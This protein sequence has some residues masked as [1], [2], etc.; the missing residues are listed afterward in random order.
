M[1]I[2]GGRDDSEQRDSSDPFIVTED[3]LRPGDQVFVYR[4]LIQH[5]G[6]VTRVA[7]RDW[8]LIVEVV[9]FD[10]S[11]DQITRVD[12]S[13]FLKGS[14]GKRGVLRRAKFGSD[15]LQAAFHHSACY[16]HQADPPQ[17]VTNR[18]LRALESSAGQEGDG[19]WGGYSLLTNNCETF[20]CWCSTGRRQTLSRQAVRGVAGATVVVAVCTASTCTGGAVTGALALKNSRRATRVAS[21]V[22]GV[23]TT[24]L[25]ADWL[26]DKI[27][28]V[29]R[30]PQEAERDSS[31]MGR[32]GP[33]LPQP[34]EA[35]GALPVSLPGS[36]ESDPC[37]QWALCN[38]SSVCLAISPTSHQPHRTLT[39]SHGT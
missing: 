31:F 23:I 38:I 9:H 5:H 12:L 10:P 39:L 26:T 2:D 34:L 32:S 3:D 33:S 24:I 15:L 11:L 37:A 6:I 30:S 28:G 16:L 36:F 13:R 22:A 19:S 21:M 17:I 29:A 18:A 7:V 4:G 1:E 25:A 35:G 27:R 8:E 14:D 20:A